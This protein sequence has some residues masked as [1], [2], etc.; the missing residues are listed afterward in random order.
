MKNKSIRILILCV[1]I[2]GVLLFFFSRKEE[3]KSNESAA[4]LSEHG[5]SKEPALSAASVPSIV[6]QNV[7]NSSRA[8]N[9]N[10][11]SVNG[12]NPRLRMDKKLS[13]EEFRELA[14]Y[15]TNSI[16][17]KSELK[18]LS[19]EEVH[20]TPEKIMEAGVRLGLIA[21]AIENEPALQK[22]GL[23]FYQSC[24]AASKNPNS[25]RALC[26]ANYLNFA[27]KLGIVA[28]E[29]IVPVS[30]KKTLSRIP[31]I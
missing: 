15:V 14:K 2:V 27:K 13:R 9:E 26:Y 6:P 18:K 16:P 3:E 25:V 21:Q 4:H 28:N 23:E 5:S 17:S 31:G 12:S 19:A 22:D 24:A 11:K 10:N 20:A 7:S 30:V 29:N 8:T 1:A